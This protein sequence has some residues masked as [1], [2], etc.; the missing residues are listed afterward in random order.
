MAF[1]QARKDFLK[2]HG[3]TDEQIATFE[4]SAGELSATLKSLGVEYKDSSLE[5]EPDPAPADAAAAAAAPT[6]TAVVDTKA[7]AEFQTTVLTALQQQTEA[8][9]AMAKGL[10]QIDARVK[11]VEKTDDEK[12]AAAIAPKGAGATAAAVAASKDDG[13]IVDVKQN[14]AN[15]DFFKGTF[16][17]PLIG[18][19]AASAAP[20]A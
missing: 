6:T 15:A 19:G 16:L 7:V 3:V 14:D 8:M 17:A 18:T 1:T 12:I 13:N 10:V 11:S 5:P 2:T 9:A 4:K 20:A